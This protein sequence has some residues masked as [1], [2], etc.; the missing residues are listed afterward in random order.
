MK[1]L[2]ESPPPHPRKYIPH[3][4]ILCLCL[5]VIKQPTIKI[6][7]KEAADLKLANS[8]KAIMQTVLAEEN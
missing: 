1:A 6:Y 8:Y 7:P 4:S 5:V 2:Q 3:N